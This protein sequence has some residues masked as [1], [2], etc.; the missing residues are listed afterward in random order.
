MP[1]ITVHGGP[2]NAQVT[3]PGEE[4]SSA[5]NDGPTVELTRDE[6]PNAPAVRPGEHAAFFSTAEQREEREER[7][8]TG[9]GSGEALPPSE[10]REREDP[11]IATIRGGDTGEPRGIEPTP[12]KAT[13]RAGGSK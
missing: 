12:R 3:P 13:K 10:D 1:K 8:V 2:S 7:E 9:D 5:R 6:D 11:A 4:P